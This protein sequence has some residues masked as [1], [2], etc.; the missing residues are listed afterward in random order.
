M[1]EYPAQRESLIRRIYG[2]N[3]KDFA[4]VAIDLWRFQYE[5]NPLY[6]S[7]CD[8][9]V[10]D[11]DKIRSL[12]DIPYLPI[13]MFRDHEIMTGTWKSV[14]IFKSSGTTG[15]RPGLH[16]VSDLGW[17]HRIAEK[18]FT[19]FYGDPDQYTWLALLPTY[20]ERPDS[21]LVDMVQ[22][23]MSRNPV[24]KHGF[25]PEP[26]Q[27]LVNQLQLLAKAKTPT[28]LIGVSFALLDLFEQHQLP[29]WNEL[30]VIETG[31]MKG[32]REEITRN[33]LHE[34]LI[35]HHTGLHI[36]SEYGMT[37]LMSQAYSKNHLFKGGPTLKV[38]IRDISDPLWMIESGQRGVINIVDLGNMDTCSFIATDDI[39]V[40]HADGTF[41][42]LGRLDQSDIR[43]CNLLY[44]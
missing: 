38:F 7:F 39:G 1:S 29:V 28:I 5:F 16:H 19:P 24:K 30:V 25:F 13:T 3:E 9:L 22:Y 12:K 4:S 40:G 21:S 41:E 15:S 34:R 17:Y 14:A 6:R 43:G 31:G 44:T 35:R 11:K 26:D 42:V 20:L 2:I 32:R 18:C 27:S 10:P 8:T 33:E 36:A 23:F 37:E